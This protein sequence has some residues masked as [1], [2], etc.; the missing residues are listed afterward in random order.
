MKE[1]KTQIG[2]AILPSNNYSLF[3]RKQEIY[4]SKKYNTVRG[5]LQPPHVT[6][7]WP[8]ETDEI[9]KFDEYCAELAKNIEPF[10]VNAQGYGF[11]EPEVI[12]LKILPSEE[13]LNLHLRILKDLKGKFGIDKNKFEGE[14]QQFHTTL[15]Y[16]DIKESEFYKA[17]EELEKGEQPELSF[18][19]N[20]IGLFKYTGEEW[21]IYKV[22]EVRNEES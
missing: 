17:K 7:K 14:T 6:I 2:I 3:V 11:F 19:F 9:N 21:I 1:R 20:K 8:F 10:I 12:F 18:K 5:L 4:L 13:L 22:F 15:A 16:E